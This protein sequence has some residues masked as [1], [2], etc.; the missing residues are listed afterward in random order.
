MYY[1]L[2]YLDLFSAFPKEILGMTPG[3]LHPT[4]QRSW[5][6]NLYRHFPPQGLQLLLFLFKSLCTPA[7]RASG[8]FDLVD[9][10]FLRV[11]FIHRVE[12]GKTHPC[13]FHSLFISQLSVNLFSAERDLCPCN[14]N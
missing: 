3:N 7:V 11:C 2:I 8:L 4:V 12:E 5:V 9:P 10:D 13:I 14:L 6:P 1:F